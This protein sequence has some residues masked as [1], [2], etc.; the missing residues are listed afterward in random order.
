LETSLQWL[1]IPFWL[2]FKGMSAVDALHR[3]STASSSD[4]QP[5]Q[6]EDRVHSMMQSLQVWRHDEFEPLRLGV[7]TKVG[8]KV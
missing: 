1:K 8:V 6:G 7:K 5:A 3:D 4:Q 2:S